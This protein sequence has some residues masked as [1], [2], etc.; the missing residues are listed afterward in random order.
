MKTLINALVALTVLAGVVG[1][2]QAFDGR[3]FLEQQEKDRW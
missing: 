2:A 1:T 3:K